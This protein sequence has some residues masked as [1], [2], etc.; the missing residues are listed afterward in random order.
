MTQ[1][2]FYTMQFSPKPAG[3]TNFTHTNTEKPSNMTDFFLKIH[4]YKSCPTSHPGYEKWKTTLL[5]KKARS[6]ENDASF[7]SSTNVFFYTLGIFLV[8]V[9]V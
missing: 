4:V 6:Y 1:N 7:L 2:P 8:S 5:M 9:L 3:F